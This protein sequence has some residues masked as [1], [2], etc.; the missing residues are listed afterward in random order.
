MLPQKIKLLTNEMDAE[1]AS[2]RNSKTRVCFI[3]MHHLAEI[4][5]GSQPTWRS[6]AHGSG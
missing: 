5:K 3:A 2:H 1:R 6:G 4:H